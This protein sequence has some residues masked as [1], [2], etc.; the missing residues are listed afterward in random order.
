MS[1]PVRTSNEAIGKQIVEDWGSLTWLASAQIGNAKGLTVGRVIIKKG[2]KNPK[3]THPSC[4][5][6]LYLLAGKLEHSCGGE[7]F[8][9]EAGDTIV[10]PAGV[11]HDAVS[12]GEEDADMM[13]TYSSGDRDF[14]LA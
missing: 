12:I 5:E 14:Q 1:N 8:I 2:M 4:E 10:I 11:A 13:V 6:A 7:Q 9:L 3:H